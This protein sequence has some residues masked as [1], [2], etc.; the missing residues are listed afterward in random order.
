MSPARIRPCAMD[1]FFLFQQGAIARTSFLVE[2]ARRA[3]F[4]NT[5]LL[6]DQNM[7][8]IHRICHVVGNVEQR[9]RFEVSA[10]ALQEFL[11]AVP[12]ESACGFIEDR[13]AHRRA[14]QRPSHS[15]TAPVASCTPT[16][17]LP[18]ASVPPR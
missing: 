8:K 15:D 13:E 11:P 14:P 7:V 16:R 17:A 3:L 1:D 10:G 18:T 4:K 9:G 12:V 5:A 2:F 6:D